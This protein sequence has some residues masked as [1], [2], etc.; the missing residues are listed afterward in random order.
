M[1]AAVRLILGSGMSLDVV[2]RMTPLR[3]WT[4]LDS[5]LEQLEEAFRELDLEIRV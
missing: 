4:G 5:R 1:P 2:R 3:E